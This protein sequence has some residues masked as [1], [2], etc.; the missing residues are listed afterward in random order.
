MS[1]E[2]KNSV[3]FNEKCNRWSKDGLNEINLAFT[4][5]ITLLNDANL[6]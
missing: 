3:D 6:W 5:V 4:F 1:E 2:K